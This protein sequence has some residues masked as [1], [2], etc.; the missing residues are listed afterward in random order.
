MII[1]CL[2]LHNFG[3]YAGTNT[4]TFHGKQPIV[5][6]GGLNGRGKTTFLEAVL[7]ALY[8]SNSFAFRESGFKSYSKYLNSYINRN[9]GT[10]HTF[11]EIMFSVQ[12]DKENTYI[13]NRSWDRGERIREKIEV[14]KNGFYSE[15]LTKNWPMF[16]ENLLPSAL[17]NFFFFDGEK[18]AELAVD[19]TNTELKNSIRAMLGLGTLD[20]LDN[21]LQRIINR[22]TKKIHKNISVEEVEKLRAISE[23]KE[24]EY[25]ECEK[26]L[27]EKK[28]EL[29]NAQS[30]LEN[31]QTEYRTQGGEIAEDSDKTHKEISNLQEE[32]ELN[33]GKMLE[34]AMSDLPMAMVGDLIAHIDDKAQGEYQ[35][36]IR[37]ESFENLEKI[38]QNYSG[39]KTSGELSQFIEYVKDQMQIGGVQE[40]SIFNL[41]DSA[42]E[43]I[44]AL[45]NGGI[46]RNV[47]DTRDL[48]DQQAKLQKEID[49]RDEQL[50]SD[51]TW[52]NQRPEGKD[53]FDDS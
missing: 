25:Q 20:T 7:L 42:R 23:Q 46:E 36:K 21:D 27:Q 11:V 5:L 8:G 45:A 22:T 40:Q 30:H 34:A 43:H 51:L 19:N 18:I 16:V 3:V 13:V 50:A 39:S 17:S 29:Q 4:F 44:H 37:Q 41:T 2:T 6:I 38:Y 48:L 53:Q 47:K 35:K 24:K 52:A 26:Q 31:L 15:Y 33:K 28:T 49:S 1:N 14:I 32:L 9:D 12:E 10:L